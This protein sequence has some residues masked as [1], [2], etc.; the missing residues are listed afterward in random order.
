MLKQITKNIIGQ[1][2][3]NFDYP[4]VINS[5]GRSGSTVLTKSIVDSAIHVNHSNLRDIASRSISQSA[6]DLEKA[7]LK[8]GIVY[9]TH[10]YPPNDYL[11]ENMK[12]LYTFANPVDVVLS[13]LRLFEER[14]EEWIKL[15]YDHLGVTYTNSFDDIIHEDQLML[16]KHL[17]TWLKEL[18]IP[19]AFIRYE[20]MWDYQDDIS[21][22]LGFDIHMPA[23]RERKS[24]EVSSK[25]MST[26]N[27]NYKPLITKI[28]RLND[29]FT[30]KKDN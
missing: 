24:K 17:D 18:R 8:N 7:V 21:E 3:S 5:Y 26:I 23:Y 22:F 1:S 6:W 9:K 11:N 28:E 2:F 27:D 15:H 13:L 25:L 12:M 16:E 14:G 30:N 29:F 19:I 4:L 10:D 20:T